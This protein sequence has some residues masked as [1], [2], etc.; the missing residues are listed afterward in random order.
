M[1][2]ALRGAARSSAWE[3]VS[4]LGR[5]RGL[6][7]SGARRDDAPGVTEMQEW[8]VIG[9]ADAVASGHRQAAATARGWR[10]AEREAEREAGCA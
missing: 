3:G 4:A 8:S 1:A 5:A 7:W 2:T 10:E 6:R 9:G